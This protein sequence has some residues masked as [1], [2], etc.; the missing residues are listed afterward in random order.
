MVHHLQ[1][2]HKAPGLR[3][4]RRNE[5]GTLLPIVNSNNNNNFFFQN[6]NLLTDIKYIN[7]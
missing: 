3:D 4:P 2:P 6:I 5:P 1:G 7:L